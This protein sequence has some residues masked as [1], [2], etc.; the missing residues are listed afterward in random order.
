MKLFTDIHIVN[1]N[2][3]SIL[4]ELSLLGY[5]EIDLCYHY[6]TGFKGVNTSVNSDLRNDDKNASLRISTNSTGG[7]IISDFG[8]KTGMDIFGYLALKYFTD[9]KEG[10]KQA[11]HKVSNDLISKT[12]KAII[13]KYNRSIFKKLPVIIE[14]L[15][16]DWE[17]RDVVFWKDSFGIPLEHLIIKGTIKPIIRFR[18][19]NPNKNKITLIDNIPDLCYRYKINFK[20]KFYNKI[21]LPN[22]LK[23]NKEFKW[24]SNI[25][26]NIILN[27]NPKLKGKLLII[28][29]S[30]KDCYVMEA[31]GYSSVPLNSETM[32]FPNTVWEILKRNYKKIIYFGN[33][34]WDKVENPGIMLCKI[35]SKIY[36]IPYIHTPDNTTSDISDYVKKYGFEKAKYLTDHLIKIYEN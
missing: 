11:L 32:W 4:L 2:K 12:S 1:L 17:D 34:D 15:S 19:S 10:Y 8:L 5:N 6:I 14:S 28:Q 33:N 30:L 16:R 29:T 25:P 36:E 7:V 31:M 24:V 13:T 18:I 9:S 35:H 22:G 20:G 3:K 23:G 27:F 26:R 21:Y